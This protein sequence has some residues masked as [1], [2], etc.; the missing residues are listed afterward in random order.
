MRS[1]PEV[2]KVW[3]GM[4]GCKPPPEPLFHTFHTFHTCF[5]VARNDAVYIYARRVMRT[6]F[7]LGM[8][9]MEG[10]EQARFYWLAAFHT[11]VFRYG[12]YGTYSNILKREICHG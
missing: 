4:E 2:W 1:D 6:V 11:L 8:E 12:R 10:M 5:G 9:G 3:Q 7:I